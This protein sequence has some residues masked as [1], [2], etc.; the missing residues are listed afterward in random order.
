[1]KT[2]IDALDATSADAYI[3]GMKKILEHELTVAQYIREIEKY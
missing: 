1:M 2:K 3:S